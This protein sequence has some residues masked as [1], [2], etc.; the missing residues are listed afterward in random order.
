MTATWAE[1]F[2]RAGKYDVTLEDVRMAADD[3]TATAATEE[4][5]DDG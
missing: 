5:S 1:L 3:Q 2:D 4:A